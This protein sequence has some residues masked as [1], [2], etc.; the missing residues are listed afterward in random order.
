VILYKRQHFSSVKV[1]SMTIDG[2]R[3]RKSKSEPFGKKFTGPGRGSKK[4]QRVKKGKRGTRRNSDHHRASSDTEM[5]SDTSTPDG[6]TT[7]KSSTPSSVPYTSSDSNA[8]NNSDDFPP[9]LLIPLMGEF[10]DDTENVPEISVKDALNYPVS[11]HRKRYNGFRLNARKRKSPLTLKLERAKEQLEE[12]HA[13][14]HI[15][16]KDKYSL[17]DQILL[18]DT[19]VSVKANILRKMN[20]YEK[21][22]SGYDQSKFNNWVKDVLQL[23]FDRNLSLSIGLQDGPQKIKA[24]LDW[25]RVSLDQAIAGQQHAKEE[26]V[27]YIARLISNPNS[28]GSIL[29]LVGQKGVGKTKLVRKGIAKVLNRPFHVINL[30]GM[31]DVHV[32]TGHDLTYTGAK[33]GKFAQILVQSQCTNPVVYLDEID[34]IQSSNDKA[35]EIFRVL[36]HVLDEEQNHEFYDEYFG[37]VAIDLSNVLFVASLNNADDVEPVLRDRL[38]LVK[39]TDLDLTTKCD[40]VRNYMLPELTAEMS[41]PTE[42]VSLSDDALKY[43]INNKTEREE[44]CRQLK[45]KM[46]T[47]LQKLNT[48]RI[49]KTGIFS[50]GRETV[51]LTHEVIDKLLK[52]SDAINDTVPYHIYN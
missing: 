33:Y 19:D 37:N 49:T 42:T 39:M 36:T 48:Q 13:R 12:Y 44:G 2:K 9:Y 27:D 16:D 38:K 22:K 43:V 30:G 7:D 4:I 23:P 3:K 52:H 50:D 26:V 24:Y 6:S 5:R 17:K 45:R 46:E 41:M 51:E 20:D 35:M 15:D 29:A 34:K 47:I 25:V 14:T 11:G 28:K 32:L 40:I 21:S 18:M 31:N 10:A 8:E 1:R